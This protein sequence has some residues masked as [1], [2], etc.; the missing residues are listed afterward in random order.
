[1]IKQILFNGRVEVGISEITDG[2]MRFFGEGDESEIIKNQKKLG[3]LIGLEIVARI[4]TIYAGRNDYTEYDEITKENL[5]KFLI[6]NPENE[7]PVSDGLVTKEPEIGLLLPLAD[8]LGAV[9]FDE[10][11]GIVGLLHAGRQ[12][13]E[14]EGPRK[15]M[16]YLVKT[17]GSRAEDIKLFFSPYALNY[18]ILKLDNKSMEEASYEQFIG[19]GILP[20]NIIDHKID[21]VS[22][23]RFPSNSG[24]DATKRFAI[25]VKMVL[26]A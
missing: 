4:R 12:N 1:M 26:N 14:Q 19:M 24:G 21:N 5:S 23:D 20:E 6:D 25:V 16:E 22:D 18:Q 9:V 17:F 10:K 15:F 7:I 3:E 2:G 8:C 11:K 13:I